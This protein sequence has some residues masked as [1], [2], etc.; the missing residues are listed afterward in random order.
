MSADA[1]EAAGIV[2]FGPEIEMDADFL[3]SLEKPDEVE[4]AA[5]SDSALKQH[6]HWGNSAAA[7]IEARKQDAV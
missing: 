1:E 3:D 7:E 4:I 6:Y 5:T 2:V